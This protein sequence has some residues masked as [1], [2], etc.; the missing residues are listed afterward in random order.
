[1]LEDYCW[2]LKSDVRE[3]NYR[4]MSCASTF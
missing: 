4:R 1:M 3:A 2:T